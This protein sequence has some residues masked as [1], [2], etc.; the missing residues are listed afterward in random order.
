M[1][2]DSGSPGRARIGTGAPL[3]LHFGVIVQPYAFSKP[4]KAFRFK[5]TKALRAS[6]D[7]AI[8]T[9]D[10]AQFLED[11]YGLMAAFYRVHQADVAEALEGSLSGALEALMGGH[12]V[13]PFGSGA[14]PHMWMRLG[15][16][17]ATGPGI[18][19]P[20]MGLARLYITSSLVRDLDRVYP[21]NHS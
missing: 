20:K 6:R 16:S 21:R 18:W 12:E 3:T 13:D 14:Q 4:I 5:S 1:A 10:V 15:A 9:G 7:R 2:A 19:G 11:Q 17:Q 8:T